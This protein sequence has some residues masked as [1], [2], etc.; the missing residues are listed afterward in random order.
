M[1]PLSPLIRRLYLILFVALFF[2]ILPVAIFY[3]DGWRYK[4]GYGFA[5]TGGIYV[6]VPYQG[7][8]ISINGEVVGESGF[9]ARSFYVGDLAPSAYIVH[10]TRDGYRSWDRL[11][12]VEEQLVTD[13]RAILI[14]SYI[15]ITRLLAATSSVSQFASTT[16]VVTKT[17][18]E[19]YLDAFATSTIASST[20][21][22]DESD[23]IAL[24]MDKNK[25]VAR[26]VKEN[27]FPP[28]LFCERP[29]VCVTE[30]PLAQNVLTSARFYGG[31]VVYATKEGKIFFTEIDLRQT[32]VTALL[33]S[34]KGADIRV[35]DGGLY[36]KSGKDLYQI[37]L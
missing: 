36:L 2:A 31:G 13:T 33:Y 27:A 30:M 28:S 17:A 25:L 34:A 7:A 8:T 21:P 10:V 16:E 32:P 37:E 18:Y 15:P 9:L 3:A 22:L 5:R 4:P 24:F 26:W 1:Q 29:T 35:V 20:V 11:L 19:S 12:V 14:P 23:G 6:T